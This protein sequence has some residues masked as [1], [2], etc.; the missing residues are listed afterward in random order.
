M[1]VNIRPSITPHLQHHE[2]MAM[3]ACSPF[4][5]SGTELQGTMAT[6]PWHCQYG[7]VGDPTFTSMWVMTAHTL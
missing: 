6:A 3:V 5:A 1:K 2:A 7:V 4:D